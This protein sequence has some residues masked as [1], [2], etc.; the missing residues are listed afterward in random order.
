MVTIDR[1][2]GLKIII[3]LH[4]HP[5]AHV[6]IKNGDGEVRIELPI[7]DGSK[8][9]LMSNDGMKKRDAAL[10]LRLVRD[11]RQTYLGFWRKI[12]G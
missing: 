3:Y 2:S 12:H 8:P 10:A 7:D 6:H 11:N 9:R 5:P 1:A 4:D